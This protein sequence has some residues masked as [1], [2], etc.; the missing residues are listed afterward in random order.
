MDP[1]TGKIKEFDSDDEAIK[2]G[3]T[4]PV[5]CKPKASCKKCY[6][7]GYVGTNDAGHKVPCACVKP[8]SRYEPSPETSEP[9]PDGPG[10]MDDE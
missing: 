9:Q 5:G 1:R 7:R 2:A 4:I 3:Y 10:G 6:G 8:V